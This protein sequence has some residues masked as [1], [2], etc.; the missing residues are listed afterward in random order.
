MGG[1][2]IKGF[3]QEKEI[4]KTEQQHSTCLIISIRY[5]NCLGP[6]KNVLSVLPYSQLEAISTAETTTTGSEQGQWLRN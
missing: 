4:R 5:Y 6:R 1:G 3:E 2:G